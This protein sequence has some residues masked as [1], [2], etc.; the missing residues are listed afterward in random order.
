MIFAVEL[1][2]TYNPFTREPDYYSTA[3]F[4]GDNI[5]ADYF[6][7]DGSLL[8]GIQGVS[9]IV[10]YTTSNFDG[11]ISLGGDIGYV[12]ANAICGSNFTESHF[13]QKAEVLQTINNNNYTFTGTAWFANGPPGYTANADD[14]AG[15]TSN[16]NTYLGPFWN[17]DGNA[18][19]GYAR[20]TNCAQI[21]PLMCC[22]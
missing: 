16:A 21:K 11:N 18:Q 1:S 15:W 6:I 12:A 8:T 9:V 17:W 14:C 4:S 2:E 5:T 20:L 7:G 13:C 22:L 10:G 3:N 19:A